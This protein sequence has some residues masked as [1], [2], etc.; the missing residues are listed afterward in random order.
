MTETARG[1][2]LPPPSRGAAKVPYLAGLD[3]MRALAVLGV[4]LYHAEI[5][6]MRG[7]FLGVDVF[8]VISGYLIT[9][10]LVSEHQRTHRIDAKQFWMRRARRLLP[11][12]YALLF[13]VTVI[14]VV[15]VR[16]DLAKLKG[17][18]VA[19]LTYTTN[20]YLIFTKES[21]FDH[22]GRPPLLQ[23][24]WSLA[25]EEQFYLLW[26]ILLA[27]LLKVLRRRVDL[28]AIVLAVMV[29]ASTIWMA[30]LYDAA[31]PSRAYYGT[32][33]R[34]SALLLG[35]LLAL[36]W[37]PGHL[38]RG[39][40]G[41]RGGRVD[42]IA[43]GGLGLLVLFAIYASATGSFLYYG[44]FLVA[45]LATLTV[46]AATA[47]PR[48]HLAKA[49][50]V[51]PL[52]WIGLRSYAIYLWH[53]PVFCLTR[54]GIDVSWTTTQAFYVRFGLTFALAEASYRYIELPF[55]AGAIRK[56]M[57][58]MRRATGEERAQRMR[59]AAWTGVAATL[60]IG[61]LSVSVATAKS[62]A[63]PIVASLQNGSAALAS[64]PALI[65]NDT[66]SAAARAGAAATTAAASRA[67]GSPA[68]AAPATVA[69]TTLP[70]QPIRLIAIGDSVMLGAAPQMKQLLGQDAYVDARVGR[71]FKEAVGIVD[72]LRD[73]RK[74]GTIVVIGLGN[75][76]SVS[77]STVDDVLQALKTVP[78]VVVLN[79]RVDRPWQDSVNAI[80]A[81]HVT[82]YP[83]VRFVDWFAAS[84][85][86]LD[87]LYGDG[88]HLR[89]QGATLYASL[90]QHAIAG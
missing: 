36:F 82:K 47:H 54:P 48:S 38:S 13:G 5:P 67:G 84:G 61:I 77:D 76:G 60:V 75:N 69:P 56:W 19:A 23:H 63:N 14:C 34:A 49:L 25:V 66:R 71:Q 89:P 31:D 6:W 79:T 18:L 12:L 41:E 1:A 58:S 70:P 80:L 26:P 53:W 65:P 72:W 8:F 10:L 33:T 22:L 29:L 43:L 68:S 73:N 51:R 37:R 20:W 87:Y 28:L 74:L 78:R 30:V 55:R 40:V 17:Q 83:N 9:L 16:E 4:M 45:G 35:A 57:A 7:G 50:G 27:V 39:E 11:A 24:L 52:R 88:T 90:I 46:I 42:L 2:P 62:E 85:P 44:G 81:A 64:Q 86:H 59:T 32:D 21:Y 3:G 15:W